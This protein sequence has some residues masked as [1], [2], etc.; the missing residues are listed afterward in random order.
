MSRDVN[1]ILE[2]LKKVSLVSSTKL[3][4]DR[5]NFL[6]TSLNEVYIFFLKSPA[7]AVKTLETMNIV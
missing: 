1:T 6:T 4:L 5:L 2:N 7:Y 3:K